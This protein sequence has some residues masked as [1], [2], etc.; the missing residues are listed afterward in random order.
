[1]LELI[2]ELNDKHI[3]WKYVYINNQLFIKY[4]DKL[5]QWYF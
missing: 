2:K 3:K 4:D 5:I 1:M